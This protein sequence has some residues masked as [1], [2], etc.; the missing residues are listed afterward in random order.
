MKIISCFGDRTK[1]GTFFIIVSVSQKR[2]T[3]NFRNIF[4]S[5]TSPRVF[6]YRC[7]LHNFL[8]MSVGF[9]F[10]LDLFSFLVVL[11]SFFLFFLLK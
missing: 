4:N 5:F 7:V 8:T 1:S 11:F 10:N 9:N 3:D 6:S 2:M